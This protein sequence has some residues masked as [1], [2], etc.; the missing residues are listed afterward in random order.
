M[1]WKGKS[2][3]V[4]TNILILQNI[5]LKS[6]ISVVVDNVKAVIVD[7]NEDEIIGM[8]KEG[9]ETFRGTFYLSMKHGAP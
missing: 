7:G 4:Y 3:L 5:E 2:R 9:P 8:V 6:Y 1:R